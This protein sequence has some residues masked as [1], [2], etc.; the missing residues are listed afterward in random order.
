MDYPEFLKE[1]VRRSNGV[2][3]EHCRILLASEYAMY[4][5]EDIEYDVEFGAL[6]INLGDEL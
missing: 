4:E 6:V 1:L 5:V 3:L 2:P